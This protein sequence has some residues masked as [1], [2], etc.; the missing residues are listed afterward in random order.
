MGVSGCSRFVFIEPFADAATP[1][2]CAARSV[3]K[4]A[5]LMPDF[6]LP[7]VRPSFASYSSNSESNRA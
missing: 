6:S 7:I 2:G 3:L 1:T 5:A 4:D